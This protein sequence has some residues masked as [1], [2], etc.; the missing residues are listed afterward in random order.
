MTIVSIVQPPI[1]YYS[2]VECLKKLQKGIPDKNT[3]MMIELGECPEYLGIKFIPDY[4]FQNARKQMKL[5]DFI[6]L[7]SVLER[8]STAACSLCE[9]HFWTSIFVKSFVEKLSSKSIIFGQKR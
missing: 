4:I 7:L 3:L 9:L 8:G 1:D 5:M 6:W 2:W